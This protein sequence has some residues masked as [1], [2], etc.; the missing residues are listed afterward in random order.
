V[1]F[2]QIED[3][4]SWLGSQT[5][6]RGVW[7]PCSNRDGLDP[8]LDQ[9]LLENNIKM[10]LILVVNKWG[11]VLVLTILLPSF[12]GIDKSTI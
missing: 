7:Q 1:F 6:N 10:L 11:A 2:W 12:I 3:C 8:Y 9:Y 5:P 4:P